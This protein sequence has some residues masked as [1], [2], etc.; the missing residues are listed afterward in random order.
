MNGIQYSSDGCI[1]QCNKDG[2][3]SAIVTDHKGENANQNAILETDHALFMRLNEARQSF[4]QSGLR[5][6]SNLNL[7]DVCKE[8]GVIGGETSVRVDDKHAIRLQEKLA[9]LQGKVK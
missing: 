6:V 9:Y 8:K 7:S 5:N 1:N 4:K 2:S 3:F